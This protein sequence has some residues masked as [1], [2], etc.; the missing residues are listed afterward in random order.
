[1]ARLWERVKSAYV[2]DGFC[3]GCAAQAAY[4]HQLGFSQIEPPC[5][6]CQGIRPTYEWAGERAHR[7][8]GV[9]YLTVVNGGVS[10]SEV[11]ESTPGYA[12]FGGV[13]K[14]S[15]DAPDAA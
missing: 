3:H 10:R 4:G 12:G 13:T 1:V 14:G 9:P 6:A 5:G 2:A 8:A 11:Q 15:P 7:W